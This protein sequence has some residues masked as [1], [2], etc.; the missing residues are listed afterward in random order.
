MKNRVDFPEFGKVGKVFFDSII[1]PKLGAR[2]G[3]VI[4]GP[5]YGCDN[6]IIK[7]NDKQVMIVTTDPLSIIPQLGFEDSAWLT[8][9]LIAS[10]IVT[11]GI[12]PMY[13]VLDF[14]L[15]PEIKREEFE[16]YWNKFHLECEKLG[17]SIVA[18]HTGKFMGCNY[19]IV[20]GGTFIAVGD[21]DKFVSSN[22]ARPGD[23][24]VVT[25]GAAIATTGILARIFP[26]KIKETFGEE[27]QLEAK[28]YFWKFSVV[29]DALTAVSIGV[30]DAGITAMH[31]ATEFGVIGG[32]YELAVSSNCGLYIYKD[33]IPVSDVTLKICS[34]FEI[35]PYISLSEGTLVIAVR[36][37]KVDELI[38][39]LKSKG[40]EAAEVGYLTD[41]SEGFWLESED[42]SKEELAYPENDPYWIAYANAIKKGWR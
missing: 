12:P 20:G 9:H 41:P 26:E 42:G 31:D 40:I 28:N 18:G 24:L 1:Y 4:V 16:A 21:V 7:L 27:L 23:K 14:N 33:K 37:D 25:K 36:R 19:T 11:S 22:M 10:D 32:L 39:V 29:E 13:A 15:P 35:D 5:R 6:A 38:R 8:V 17:I 34:L 2:R 3:E 30:R